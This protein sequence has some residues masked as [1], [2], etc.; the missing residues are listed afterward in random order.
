MTI[1]QPTKI[2]LVVM[3]AI[4]GTVSALSNYGYLRHSSSQDALYVAEFSLIAN[5][6][7]QTQTLSAKPSG[8][9]AQCAEGFLVLEGS[10][11]KASGNTTG[12]LVD[13]RRRPVRCSFAAE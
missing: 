9:A 6:P 10:S 11:N 8:F 2:I 3:I 13:A 12:V 4:V 1:N 5:A 7:G